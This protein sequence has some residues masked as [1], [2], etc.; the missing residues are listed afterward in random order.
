M[1]GALMAAG[2][3]L[4][5]SGSLN[6][7][8]LLADFFHFFCRDLIWFSC[9]F[10]PFWGHGTCLLVPWIIHD[11]FEFQKQRQN[12]V[13]S[14]PNVFRNLLVGYIIMSSELRVW[15]CENLNFQSQKLTKLLKPKMQWVS[16]RD[17]NYLTKTNTQIWDKFLQP[18][19]R[20]KKE[21]IEALKPV[22]ARSLIFFNDLWFWFFE[23][24]EIYLA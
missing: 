23:K 2:S 18:K 21:E 14:S 17:W 15:Q 9:N 11:E 7:I 8:D 20:M 19:T 4:W 5:N 12:F 13:C 22:L 3:L 16:W 1:D 6:C 10:T 24:L